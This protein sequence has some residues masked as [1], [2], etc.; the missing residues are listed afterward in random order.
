MSY[1]ISLHVLQERLDDFNDGERRVVYPHSSLEMGQAYSVLGQV[2]DLS[3]LRSEDRTD[4]PTQPHVATHP[5]PE[6]V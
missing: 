1:D 6:G 5:L 3:S 4:I 2:I